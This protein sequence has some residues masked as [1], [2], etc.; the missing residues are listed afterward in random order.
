MRKILSIVGLLAMQ[1][2]HQV[3]VLL[4]SYLRTYFIL[5]HFLDELFSE[6]QSGKQFQLVNQSWEVDTNFY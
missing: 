3:L 2:A 1:E 4:F 6:A 5:Q